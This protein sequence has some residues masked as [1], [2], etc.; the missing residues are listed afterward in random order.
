M[1]SGKFDHA[2]DEGEAGLILW[3]FRIK[4]IRY[5]KV[6]IYFVCHFFV[7]CHFPGSGSRESGGHDRVEK[8]G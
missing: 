5:E 2:V 7:V 6:F 8:R 4:R 3:M 1:Y